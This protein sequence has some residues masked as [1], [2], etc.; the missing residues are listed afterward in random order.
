M[1][2]KD[3]TGENTPFDLDINQEDLDKN[4]LIGEQ[5]PALVSE[6]ETKKIVMEVAK[7]Y[8]CTN[9]LAYI[10]ICIICQKGGSARKAQ[11]NIFV[12]IGGKK[13]ELGGIRNAISTLKSSVT[14]RQFA[15]T[16]ATKIY[17]ICKH[18][19]IEG[20]LQKKALRVHPN[21]S[22]D[23]K[24]WLSNFQMDNPDCPIHIRNFLI[25]HYNTTVSP[26]ANINFIG[27]SM[28]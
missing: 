18:Y 28:Q 9:K 23:D 27:R 20:D 4:L 26:N 5:A 7:K 24:I 10:G 15:R 21:M 13:I 11:P 22:D 25:H 12:S 3:N 2:E 19:G 16:H 6:D 1:T 17:T 14:L 8:N